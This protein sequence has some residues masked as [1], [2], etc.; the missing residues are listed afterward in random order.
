MLCET[1][2]LTALLGALLLSLASTYAI[3]SPKCKFVGMQPTEQEQAD[4]DELVWYMA[5]LAGDAGMAFG[6]DSS[7]KWECWTSGFTYNQMVTDGAGNILVLNLET[8]IMAH[9]PAGRYGHV[10]CLDIVSTRRFTPG[11]NGKCF[12]A[13][14]PF[15]GFNAR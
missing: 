4:A 9:T 14:D 15:K 7:S 1:K 13:R 2:R 10:M 8:R 3:S 5:F 11:A 6:G 12:I